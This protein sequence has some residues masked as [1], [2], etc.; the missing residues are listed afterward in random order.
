MRRVVGR[1][2]PGVADAGGRIPRDPEISPTRRARALARHDRA[3]RVR[4]GHL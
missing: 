2:R 4:Q 1:L 3:W